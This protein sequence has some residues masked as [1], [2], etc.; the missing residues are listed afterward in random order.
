MNCFLIRLYKLNDYRRR[1]QI[2]RLSS[3]KKDIQKVHLIDYETVKVDQIVGSQS[4]DWPIKVD[5]LFTYEPRFISQAK[6][7]RYAY[8]CLARVRHFE[9]D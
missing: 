3:K 8:C 7:G 6:Q 5:D 9:L 4:N 1:W 2:T